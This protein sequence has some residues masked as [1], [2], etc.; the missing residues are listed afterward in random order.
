MAQQDFYQVLGVSEQAD[1]AEIKKAYR[2][3]AK[4]YHPDANP[5][6]PKA[7]ERFKAISEA[8]GVLSD[9]EKR[10]KYDRMR[11]LGAF[12]SIRTSRSGGARPRGG[13]A[14]QEESF[15]FGDIGNFGLG[16]IFSSIFGKRRGEER[17]AQPENVEVQ[18]SVPFRTAAVGGKV[19]V[20]LTMTDACDACGGKGAAPG[21]SMQTC[22]ECDGRGTISFG[23]GGFAVNRPCPACRGRGSIPSTPCPT[24]GGSGEQRTRKELLVTVPPA[25]ET[26]TRVRLK[27]QGSHRT[28]G[29]P[30]SD[31]L[32]TFQVESDRF[33]SRDGLDILCTIPIAL[34]QAVLGTTVQVKTIGGSKVK[35][36][37]PAGTQPGKKFRVR[38]QGLTKG[39]QTGDQI[40]TV[41]VKIPE[42]L[43]PEQ[44]KAFREFAE[45][46]RP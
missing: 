24:C 33:F 25:T 15:D 28:A 40:V 22:V 35:L 19:P 8:H 31:L 6:D 23:Q 14:P 10:A 42:K 7:A 2:K 34:S 39:G 26:G 44:E 12:D 36:R 9:A 5:N 29:G 3:L 13:A 45:S 11:K 17:S 4:Q 16:D 30:K 37:I 43:T 38:G 1:A 20:T 27:G 41:N 21:A 18:V 32:I 46:R